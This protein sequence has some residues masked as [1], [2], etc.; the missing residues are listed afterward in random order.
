MKPSFLQKPSRPYVYSRLAVLFSVIVYI[1]LDQ[2][3]KSLAVDH[4]KG[5]PSFVII[6][7]VIRFTYV[8]NRGAA[9]GSFADSRWVFM[10]VS[11]VA[12]VAI[13]AYLLYDRKLSRL[14]LLSLSFIL[15]GGIGNMI[16]RVS[17]GYVV[18]FI[19]FYLIDFAVFNVA[20]SFVTVGCI[21][22]IAILI[23]EMVKEAKKE[24]PSSPK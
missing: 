20:D 15:A 4:L 1:I 2:V 6:P 17:L 10:V 22:L 11:S 12:I 19:D 14:S 5:K 7:N 18:D 24:K 9:F 21:L 23:F 16:D 8:E 13:I 3:T